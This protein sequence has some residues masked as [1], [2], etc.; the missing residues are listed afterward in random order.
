MIHNLLEE[1]LKPKNYS[2]GIG[3]TQRAVDQRI[4]GV[5]VQVDETFGAHPAALTGAK[6]RRCS[7]Q[8]P[9]LRSRSRCIAVP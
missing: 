1:P 5:D 9:A 6:L 2:S 8:G 7:S 3:D 4:L